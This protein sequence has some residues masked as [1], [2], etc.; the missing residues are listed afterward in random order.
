M[1]AGAYPAPVPILRFRVPGRR[2]PI[3]AWLSALLPAVP[4]A[5]R[6]VWFDAGAVAI[7]G[8]PCDRGTESCPPGAQVSVEIGDMQRAALRAGRGG[9]AAERA[10]RWIA[11]V[12]DVP[13]SCGACPLAGDDDGLGFEVVQRAGGLARLRVDGLETTGEAVLAA[14]AGAD[15]PVVGDLE[16]GGLALPVAEGGN[17][18][19]MLAPEDA[20][21]PTDLDALAAAPAW[22]WDHDAEGARPEEDEEDEAGWLRVSVESARALASGHAWV[23][24]DAASDR[25][26]RFR[27]GALVALEARDGTDLGWARIEGTNRIAARRWSEPTDRKSV[28]SVEARVAKALARRRK[29]LAGPSSGTSA[30]RLIHGEGDDLPGLYVDRLGPLLRML[31]TGYAAIHLRERVTA[32]LLA[33]LPVT[34]EGESW[35]VLEVLH[36]RTAARGRFEATTWRAG[37]LDLLAEQGALAAD[38]ESLIARE[39][40]LAFELDPGWA[41]PR[42]PR[43]GYGLFVDQ[44]DNRARVAE[45]AHAGG[46]RWLNLF[47]HTGAFSVALLAAGADE[48][49]SVDLSAPYLARLDRNLALNVEAGVDPGRHRSVRGEARRALE[50]DPGEL[51]GIVVDPPTAAAAGRRFWSVR[52]D[53]EPLLRLAIE[54]L[55][56]GGCLLATQNRAGPPLGL[57]RVVERVARRSHRPIAGL[58]A[59]PPADDHPTRAGFPEGDPFEGALLRL[60]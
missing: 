9:V 17:A 13:W 6:R 25:A 46:G 41:A 37:G 56:D 54:R 47:A 8:R 49:T 42:R 40:G 34:P 16:R 4:R 5:E 19:P 32:A 35:S 43:P 30:F 26:E 52:D 36:L 24:P 55:G 31:V 10:K 39:R 51:R 50:N 60:A 59:A 29:W 18:A 15:M 48:V 12:D 58:E 45:L 28:A 33:Q 20:A 11:V 23:L 38:G 44:R 7:D 2:E 14:L 21:T 1:R 53:L 22:R 27:A 3:G 57:D